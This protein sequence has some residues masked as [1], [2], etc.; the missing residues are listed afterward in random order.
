ML[1]QKRGRAT[2]GVFRAR[3]RRRASAIRRDLPSPVIVRAHHR[4]PLPPRPIG[5]PAPTLGSRRELSMNM[6]KPVKNKVELVRLIP[7]STGRLAEPWAAAAGVVTVIGSPRQRHGVL[8][9]GIPPAACLKDRLLPFPSS[10]TLGCWL[11][12]GNPTFNHP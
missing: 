2:V 7:R 3:G 12:P 6:S 8:P 5:C 9:L 11:A 1:D 4:R 10:S